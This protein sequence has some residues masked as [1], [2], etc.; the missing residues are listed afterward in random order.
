[1]TKG[2]NF[3]HYYI[4]YFRQFA[5][6]PLATCSTLRSLEALTQ[7]Q[8]AGYRYSIAPTLASSSSTSAVPVAICGTVRSLEV[9]TPVAA[10]RRYCA[11]G[12]LWGQRLR[13]QRLRGATATDDDKK[14]REPRSSQR[15]EW[16]PTL[17]IGDGYGNRA[18]DACET[19]AKASKCMGRRGA[20]SAPLIMQRSRSYTRR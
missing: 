1:M 19:R 10:S 7:V 12:R 9:P 11:Q 2:Q 13:G 18:W 5:T 16:E 20:A 14:G 3:R 15:K 17:D 6:I 4:S 8:V